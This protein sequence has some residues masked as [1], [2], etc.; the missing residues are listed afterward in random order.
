[1]AKTGEK[2][3]DSKSRDLL[4]QGMSVAAAQE[5]LGIA[6]IEPEMAKQ[7]LAERNELAADMIAL[8]KEMQMARARVVAGEAPPSGDEVVKSSM[9]Q[10]PVK[11]RHRKSGMV[12]QTPAPT[13]AGMPAGV[14]S[15]PAETTTGGLTESDLR[16]ISLVKNG[17]AKARDAFVEQN[18]TIHPGATSARPEYLDEPYNN[19]YAPAPSLQPSGF[20]DDDLRIVGVG[21]Q[22][23]EQT[24]AVAGPNEMDSDKF[25]DML[26]S[27]ASGRAMLEST[28]ERV[29]PS[30]SRMPGP[31]QFAGGAPNAEP[32]QQMPNYSESVPN[33]GGYAA[34][35]EYSRD[36]AKYGS[37]KMA[38]VDNTIAEMP[39]PQVE[40]ASALPNERVRVQA[41]G[42]K[43]PKFVPHR[44]EADFEEFSEI[45]GW[46]SRGVF[47]PDKV[48]AQALKAVDAFMLSSADDDDIAN[49]MSVILG[50]R[51]RGISPEDILTAD[52]EYLMYWLRASSYPAD[53]GGGLP[54][55][56]FTCPKC[57]TQYVTTETAS[58]L[59]PITFN[60]LDFETVNDPYEIARMHSAEGFVRCT[61]FDE[62]ECHIYLRRRKH[63]RIIKEYVDEWETYYRKIFPKYKSLFLSAA[64][65]IEIEDCE[66]MTEKLEY[67]ENYPLYEKTEFF[68]KIASSQV[69]TET[70]VNIT[71]PKCGGTASVPYPFQYRGFVASL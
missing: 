36:G 10:T 40:R 12:A 47:Y 18:D 17:H 16:L 70:M 44:H 33:M 51:L 63:D 9:A 46:P 29:Q 64:A 37:G 31:I 61:T 28:P 24:G 48:Y 66:N 22:M 55:I 35:W 2:V 8:D 54:R 52:E 25:R 65:V 34:A 68:K 59:R 30:Q 57:H 39:P 53:A 1:M 38:P 11:P 26:V 71:C 15:V 3:F 60:D 43:P 4:M 6:G 42:P 69:I 7:M 56:K 20:T 41:E 23:P 67:L 32:I 5:S 19:P 14:Q 49:D 58:M 21:E 13:K 62:R 27:V 50:R 45:A